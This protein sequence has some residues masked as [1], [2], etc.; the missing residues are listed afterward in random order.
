[1]WFNERLPSEAQTILTHRDTYIEHRLIKPMH[2]QT[3][4]MVERFNGRVA[5]I[6]KKTIFDSSSELKAT[7]LRYM[8]VYNQHLS[9]KAINHA[10]NQRTLLKIS[11]FLGEKRVNYSLAYGYLGV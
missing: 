11:V 3:N 7:L 6:L 9:Q 1:M 4:G 8:L 10:T 5:T 2:P